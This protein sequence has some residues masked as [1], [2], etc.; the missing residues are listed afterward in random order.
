MVAY[1]PT[2]IGDQGSKDAYD[3]QPQSVIENVSP[4]DIFIA[5]TNANTMITSS[6]HN[7]L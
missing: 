4:H 3:T 7:T 1:A 2:D 5:L 6:S